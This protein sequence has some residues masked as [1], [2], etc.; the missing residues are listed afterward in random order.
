MFN[1]VKIIGMF[2]ICLNNL[3]RFL[4]K[5]KYLKIKEIELS[6][7]IEFVFKYFPKF[8]SFMLS[9][10]NNFSYRMLSSMF[11][12]GENQLN[13]QEIYEYIDGNY[14]GKFKQ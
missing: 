3:L 14:N 1:I 12:F 8:K 4:N 9:Y 13:G 7:Y 2:A 6:T 5:C 11:G 10:Y